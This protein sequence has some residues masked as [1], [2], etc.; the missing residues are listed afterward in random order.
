MGAF[1]VGTTLWSFGVIPY[2]PHPSHEFWHIIQSAIIEINSKTNIILREKISSDKSWIYFTCDKTK[3][4]FAHVGMHQGGT[5]VNVKHNVRALHELGHVIGMIHEHQRSDRDEHLEMKEKNFNEKDLGTHQS[6]LR[7]EAFCYGTPYDINSCMHYWSTAHCLNNNFWRNLFHDN[8]TMVY[9]FDRKLRFPCPEVLSHLDIDCINN[10]YAEEVARRSIKLEQVEIDQ[11]SNIALEEGLVELCA[12]EGNDADHTPGF[13]KNSVNCNEG[14][15]ENPLYLCCKKEKSSTL[16][17]CIQVVNT[18]ILKE[19]ERGPK[20]FQ[21]V[22]DRTGKICNFNKNKR[23]NYVSVWYSCEEFLGPPLKDVTI[24]S[25][26]EEGV[27]QTGYHR[28][29]SN[30]NKGTKGRNVYICFK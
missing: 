17:R 8:R 16:I 3:S 15:K 6:I 30:L 4:N 20:G 7:K 26:D 10:A 18:A 14:T 9:K 21:A 23:G 25:G 13:A 5:Q 29:Y 24:V 27:Y 22:R 19:F 11:D 28:I 2:E 1:R 12:L